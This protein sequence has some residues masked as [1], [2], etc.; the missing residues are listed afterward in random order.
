MENNNLNN[1]QKPDAS[2]EQSI[3]SEKQ[4]KNEEIT[5]AESQY[6]YLKELNTKLSSFKKQN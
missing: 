6:R 3:I 4:E 5:T 2:V 1:I